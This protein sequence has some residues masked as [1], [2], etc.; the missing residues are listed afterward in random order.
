MFKKFFCKLIISCSKLILPIFY[1]ILILLRINTRTIN[2]LNNQRS[3]ANNNYNFS[4]FIKDL[5]N[6]K[7]L[8]ALDIGAQDGFNSDEF[9]SKKYNTFFN[10]IM[11]EPIKEEAEKLKKK[12]DYV[13]DK[14]IW[15]SSI[16]KKIF[17]LGNR[18]GSSSMYEPNKSV[19]NIHNIKEKDYGK[20]DVTETFEIEC[21]TLSDTL[22]KININNIDY[23]KI[24][25]QGSEMEIIK[26]MENIK[27]L[28]LKI[29]V[30]IF[31]MYKN[32]NDWTE[33][34]NHLNKLN[35]MVCDWRN[36]GSHAT[37][38]PAEMDMIFIPKYTSSAGR[39]LIKNNEE[40]FT[41]LM[42]IFGQ[43]KLLKIIAKELNF[44]SLS[45]IDKFEDKFFF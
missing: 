39:D 28:L 40:K 35:Y 42:L 25:T 27:P 6:E 18:P 19:F 31:S 10:P 33:L 1:K 7:K 4:N 37:R 38:T 5:L 3:L 23:L 12:F 32:V 22:K 34:V 17:F 30:Q 44:K 2:F 21:E 43:L 20:F 13:I 11:V 16:K 24:D 14:G 36:I 9:F 41:S 8:L 29:E 26:G 45:S 15:S